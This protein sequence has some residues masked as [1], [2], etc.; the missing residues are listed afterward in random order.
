MRLRLAWL[1]GTLHPGHWRYWGEWWRGW[2]RT[3]RHNSR[4]AMAARIAALEASRRAVFALMEEAALAAGVATPAACAAFADP[5]AARIQDRRHRIEASGLQ[6][7]H[8][9]PR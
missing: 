8:G 3:R 2:R 6:L 7:I 9:G 1:A 4:K 5:V